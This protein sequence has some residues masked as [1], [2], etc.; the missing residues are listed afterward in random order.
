MNPS[1]AL[2]PH[3]LARAKTA[4][5]E[6]DLLIAGERCS[7]A[8]NRVYYAAFYAA[9]AALATVNADSSRHSGTIA[10]FQQHFVRSG[11]IL[12]DIA[13]ALPRAFEKPRPLITATSVSRAATRSPPCA[14][15][16]RRSSRRASTSSTVRLLRHER[17][18]RS[19]RFG[20]GR[21]HVGPRT[22][23]RTPCFGAEALGPLTYLIYPSARSRSSCSGV[24]ATFA[25]GVNCVASAR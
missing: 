24:S 4:L 25:P 14:I 19:S 13:K 5:D 21:S 15:R 9:R 11:V 8:L 3:P 16:S 12:G 2:A 18:G 17:R 6:A 22:R 7:G 23:L 20:P 1:D 10:L